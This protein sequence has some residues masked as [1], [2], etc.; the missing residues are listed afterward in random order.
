MT[1]YLPTTGPGHSKVGL[2]TLRPIQDT[3]T[4]SQMS[5]SYM[6]FNGQIEQGTA[7]LNNVKCTHYHLCSR[8]VFYDV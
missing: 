8:W 4:A 7:D 3:G 5:D 2:G 6:P 1:G